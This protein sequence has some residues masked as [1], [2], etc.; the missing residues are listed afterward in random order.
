MVRDAAI[1]D[2][3]LEKSFDGVLI[4][5]PCS[6]LGLL[7]DKPDIRY[8]KTDADIT[9]LVEIQKHILETCARYVKPS[10]VSGLRDLHHLPQGE[11]GTDRC[12]FNGAS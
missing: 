12:V 3:A 2:P 1:F 8:S 11:R 6:G 10:G 4:D 9:A 5:A 7:G